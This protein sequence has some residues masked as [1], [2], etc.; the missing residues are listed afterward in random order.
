M[1]NEYRITMSAGIYFNFSCELNLHFNVNV[2]QNVRVV[3][4]VA[5][6][7]VRTSFFVT[8]SSAS[9]TIWKVIEIIKKIILNI[10]HGN[11]VLYFENNVFCL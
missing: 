3:S 8:I 1:T 5:T 4:C 10:K 7:N 11:N 6:V 2:K 9:L